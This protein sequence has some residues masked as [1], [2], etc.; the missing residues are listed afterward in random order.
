MPPATATPSA[1]P[2]LAPTP[3]P[4]AAVRFRGIGRG[5]ETPSARPIHHP[6]PAPIA[7]RP[8]CRRSRPIRSV[9]GCRPAVSAPRL[10]GPPA[11]F[12]SGPARGR[13]PR[14]AGLWYG[15]AVGIAAGGVSVAVPGS[16]L[17]RAIIAGGSTPI[18][19]GVVTRRIA[20]TVS[21][22]IG[23][24]A[25]PSVQPVRRD[26][27]GLSAWW[28][29]FAAPIRGAHRRT[30]AGGTAARPPTAPTPA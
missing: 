19:R 9:L 21:G 10:G 30:I 20:C 26:A 28:A 2:P 5:R 12:T 11:A 3:D 16:G 6:R 8:P 22:R 1:R 14:D 4:T 18:G 29:V 7:R 17:T 27:A 13:V 15:A 23:A 25:A 24:G